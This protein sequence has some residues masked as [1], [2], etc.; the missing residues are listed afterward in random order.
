MLGK[1][2]SALFGSSSKPEPA[3]APQTAR[4]TIPEIPIDPQEARERDEARVRLLSASTLFKPEKREVLLK[5]IRGSINLH[6]V[7]PFLSADEKRALGLNTR[8]KFSAAFVECLTP[9]GVAHDDP[10]GALAA[11]GHMAFHKAARAQTLR[12]FKL[13]G[14]DQLEILNCGDSRDC[15]WSRKKANRL[16]PV[17]TDV[18]ALI[19]Q[20]CDAEYCRCILSPRGL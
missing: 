15:A 20:H 13:A 11:I 2:F 14:I 10:K 3:V 16:H 12:S 17:T 5:H 9:E 4:P 19:E 18:E 6:Q 8:A 7:E 1:L